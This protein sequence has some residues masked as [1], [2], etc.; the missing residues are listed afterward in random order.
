MLL[1]GTLAAGF[2]AADMRPVLRTLLVERR[3]PFCKQPQLHL[4]VVQPIAPLLL[5]LLL[6]P[7]Q[8]QERL[9]CRNPN[10]YDS[11]PIGSPPI[12]AL[13][14]LGTPS[15]GAL[16]LAGVLSAQ[17]Y[18]GGLMPLGTHDPVRNLLAGME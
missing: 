7:Q 6:G 16:L 11:V 5:Q 15:R 13:R 17:L 1:G 12:G 8:T 9:T 14:R 10:A 2:D 4:K 3:L 18:S